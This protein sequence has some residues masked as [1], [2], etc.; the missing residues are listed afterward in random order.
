MNDVLG[1]IMRVSSNVDGIPIKLL[2]DILAPVSPVIIVIFNKSLE[3]SI[4]PLDWKHALVSVTKNLIFKKICQI[5]D[6][7]VLVVKNVDLNGI[8]PMC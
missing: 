2:K 6:L 3:P 8:F 7:L 5:L 1:A 4:F